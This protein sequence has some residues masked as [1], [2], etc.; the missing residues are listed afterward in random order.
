[1]RRDLFRINWRHCAVR[2][3]TENDVPTLRG[4][5]CVQDFETGAS[6][7]DA[8][9]ATGIQPNNYINPAVPQ[10]EGVSATL[11]TEPYHCACF[12]L[13]PTEIGIFVGV[14]ARGQ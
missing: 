10:I 8:R 9:L 3:R 14:N 2:K 6:G 13:Q 12:S 4:P 11:C 7:A 1:M 5:G